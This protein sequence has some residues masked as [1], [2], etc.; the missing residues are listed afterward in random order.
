MILHSAMNR[1]NNSHHFPAF[2]QFIHE[3]PRPFQAL[4]SLP[5]NLGRQCK[6]EK[7]QNH[8]PAVP[9]FKSPSKLVHLPHTQTI[10]NSQ[11]WRRLYPASSGSTP[12]QSPPRSGHLERSWSKRRGLSYRYTSLSLSYN[13]DAN[14][15]RRTMRCKNGLWTTGPSSGPS[16]GTTSP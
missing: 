8:R 6:Q 2:L 13:P 3:L 12:I 1:W 9:D 10:N 7:S 11:P 15:D 5:H 16:A 4:P 14:T